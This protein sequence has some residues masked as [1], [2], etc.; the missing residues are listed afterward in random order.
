MKY[1]L[2][3]LHGGIIDL[4]T[5][6]E[7]AYVAV[8]NLGKYVKGMN[9]EKNDA[10]VYGPDGIIANAKLFLDENDQ[11]TGK[12]PND[13]AIFI[14]ANPCH[15]LGFL[16]ISPTEP[17]GFTD[18]AKAL[19]VLEQMRKE[20]GNHIKLYR[21]EIVKGPVMLRKDLEKHNANLV[22]ND[23]EYSLVSEY[24]E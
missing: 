22:I 9:P 21:A 18:P 16:V 12:D 11:Y 19:S 24:L 4:V 23:F 6:Y 8:A 10:V 2:I 15:S 14:I 13:K 5:F 7:D 1:V 20:H 3:T 17:I